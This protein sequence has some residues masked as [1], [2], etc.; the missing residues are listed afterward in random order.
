MQRRRETRIYWRDQGGERRAYADFRDFSDAGGRREALVPAGESAATT[1]PREAEMVMA[2]RLEELRALRQGKHVEHHEQMALGELARQHLI[3]T[4]EAQEVTDEWIDATEGFLRRAVEFFGADRQVTSIRPKDVKE[5]MRELAKII[6]NR[7]RP[8][9]KASVRHHLNALSRLYR[10]GRELEVVPLGYNPVA[11][12]L[13]KPKK[14]DYDAAYLDVHEASLFLEAARLLPPPANNP[15][16]ISTA[17]AHALVA[18]YLLTGGRHDEVLGLELDD[19]SFDRRT[20]TFRP[21]GWRRL[22]NKQSRRSVPLWPQLEAILRHYVFEVRLLQPGT[23]LFPSFESGKETMITDVRKL[24]DRIAVRS[25]FLTPQI[26]PRTGGQRRKPSGDPMWE[27]KPIR[28]RIFR[29]TYCSARLQTLDRGEPVSAFTV[30]CELGHGSEDM[31]NKVY[32]HLGDVRHRSEAV[33]YRVSQ[34]LEVLLERLK[35]LDL[36]LP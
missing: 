30:R 6:T 17:Y 19:V 33:E 9:T 2:R 36:A 4:K 35:A 26:D 20:I 23:L 34:H 8:L 24:L 29:H 12:L 15:T 25:G 18:C 13:E 7:G 21:N 28:T 27:G 31:V 10:R 16:A 3:T 32:S 14:G 22:K 11:E 1:D 5:F